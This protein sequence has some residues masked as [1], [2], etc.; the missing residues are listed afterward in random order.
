MKPVELY[1]EIAVFLAGTF[2]ILACLVEFT[3]G[4]PARCAWERTWHS[5]NEWVKTHYCGYWPNQPRKQ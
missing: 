2:V 4:Y 1:V 3:T 5:E